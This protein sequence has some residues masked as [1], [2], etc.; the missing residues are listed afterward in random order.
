[1]GVSWWQDRTWRVPRTGC[2]EGD[3]RGDQVAGSCDRN[4]WAAEASAD[5]GTDLVCGRGAN[6]PLDAAAVGEELYAG[7]WVNAE[8][9]VRLMPDMADVV[10]LY[11]QESPR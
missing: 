5:F 11:L 4:P 2:N 9:A 7:Q 6:R 10:R 8:E 1:V 3:V